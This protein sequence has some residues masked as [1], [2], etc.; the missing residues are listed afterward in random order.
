MANADYLCPTCAECDELEVPDF[1]FND[2]CDPEQNE[3]EICDILFT[4][5]DPENAGEALG[6][7][8]DWTL[9]P[10]WATAIDNTGTG[11]VRRLTVLG[12]LPEPEQEIR[13]AS[14]RRKVMGPKNFTLNGTIDDVTDA[15]YDAAR[16]LECGGVVRMWYATIGGKLYGGQEGIKASITKANMPLDRGQNTFE[17]IELQ[18]QWEHSCHPPRTD[19]P[20]A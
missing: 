5:E 17:R 4:I 13:I 11:T 3:S 16:I 12:D 1:S 8:T 6:G 15:N 18:F 14:K 9:A 20:L 2:N 7:P 10:D 19:N